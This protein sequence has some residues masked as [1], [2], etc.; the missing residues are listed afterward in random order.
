MDVSEE[1]SYL[2][3]KR[4]STFRTTHPRKQKKRDAPEE[5][6]GPPTTGLECEVAAKHS[7]RP[8]FGWILVYPCVSMGWGGEIALAAFCSAL[9]RLSY[10]GLARKTRRTRLGVRGLEPLTSGLKGHHSAD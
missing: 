9:Y 10:S 3:V 6:L 1:I 4:D 5:G 2:H 7:F 8:P